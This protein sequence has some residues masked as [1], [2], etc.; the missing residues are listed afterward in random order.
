MRKFDVRWWVT[1]ELREWRF[2]QPGVPLWIY[3][4]PDG[5]LVCP[6]FEAWALAPGLIVEF[7]GSKCESA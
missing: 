4:L 3:F 5:H 7:K 2:D 1:P 6:E